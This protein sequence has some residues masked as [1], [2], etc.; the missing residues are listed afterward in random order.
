MGK[1]RKKHPFGGITACDSEKHYKQQE[2]KRARHQIKQMLKTGAEELLHI[3][4]Y[5]NPWNGPK[6]GKIRF[7]LKRFQKGMRK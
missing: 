3:K 1:S 7:D 6:D 2:H 4:K 5:G